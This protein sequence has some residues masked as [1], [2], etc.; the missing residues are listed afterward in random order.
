M[1]IK[2]NPRILV[3]LI[4]VYIRFLY[5]CDILQCYQSNFKKWEKKHKYIL[6]C[7]ILLIF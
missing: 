3:L 4:T 7:R 6:N 5:T 2:K 1:R